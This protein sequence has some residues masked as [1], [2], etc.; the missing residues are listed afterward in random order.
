MERVEQGFSLCRTRVATFRKVHQ[1]SE[2]EIAV[3]EGGSASVLF[4]EKRRV[5]RPDE[6]SICWG[7]VPHGNIVV[8]SGKPLG[9]SL[10]IPFA[11]FVAWRLPAALVTAVLRGQFLEAGSQTQPCSDV[12]LMKHW[13]ALTTEADPEANAIVWHEVQARLC[14][15][16]RGLFA[17]HTGPTAPPAPH[18][19]RTAELFEK[20]LAAIHAR[21]QQRLTVREIGRSAG[22]GP[23]HAM[24]VFRE[25][26]DTSLHEYIIRC[27]IFTAQ[28]LL[29]T[30]S[31]KISAISQASGFR[32]SDCF[33]HAFKT[34]CGQTPRR[35]RH[36]LC[37]K[38]G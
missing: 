29:A 16:A 1:H 27:R 31:E 34:I 20:M 33:Y 21:H 10:H 6:L 25:M 3:L 36:L 13:Y 37:A 7:A 15:F 2:V 35:Y 19:N 17:S 28:R 30:T 4:G 22:I 14:R 38:P 5:R 11:L 26:G 23:D 9:Y 32:S 8:I 24:H 12:A 18:S